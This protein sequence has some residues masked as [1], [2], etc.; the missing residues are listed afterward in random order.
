MVQEVGE[1]NEKDEER[2]GDR[3]VKKGGSKKGFR[4]GLWLV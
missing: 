1:E 2:N 4:E 3:S